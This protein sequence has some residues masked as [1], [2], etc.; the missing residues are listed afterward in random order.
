[1]GCKFLQ[2][3]SAFSP[4]LTLDCLRFTALFKHLQRT[5]IRF[6]FGS[7][8]LSCKRIDL[9]LASSSLLGLYRVV[10]VLPA[11]KSIWMASIPINPTPF[12]TA[13]NDI[14]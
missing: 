5:C 14:K 7:F 9:P 8:L 2:L 1:L 6:A 13:M 12:S 3:S 4:C 11:V 10:L